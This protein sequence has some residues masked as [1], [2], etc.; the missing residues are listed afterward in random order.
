MLGDKIWEGSGR[1]TG[2][3]ILPG[4]DFRYVKLEISIEGTGKT[5]GVDATN[6]GTF[7]TFE[8]VPGQMY[9]EGQGIVMTSDGESVIWN[10]HGVGHP[11]GDG[12]GVSIRYSIAFQAGQAGKLAALNSVLGV[13]EFESKGDG[14][15]T[16]KN[17]EWK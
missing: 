11:S 16:D 4:D 14:S 17:F 2:M 9:A 8:R 12:L 1:T 6:I 10:G 5:L 3:R 13:G 15:W 7:T